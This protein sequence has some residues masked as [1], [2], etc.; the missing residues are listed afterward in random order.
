MA[1]AT[2]GMSW[3][4]SQVEYS[5]NG[6]TWTDISGWENTLAVAG[7]DRAIGEFFT[8]D[9][10]TPIITA[11]KRSALRVTVS[12]LYTEG[13]GDPFEAV[14]TEFQTAGGDPFYIRWSP[15]GGDSGDSRFATGAGEIESLAWPQGDAA[16]GDALAIEFVVAVAEI[17]KSTI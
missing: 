12:V 16:S 14:R 1:Q 11:G 17:T 9:G 5:L 2:G 4:D 8:S 15:G 13:T 10:D 3:N 6:S 7:G